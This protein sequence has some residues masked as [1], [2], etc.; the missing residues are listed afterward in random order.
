MTL[1]IGKEVSGLGKMTV[2]ELRARFAEVTGEATTS[3]HKE[4]LIRR[5][6]R[7]MQA[8]CRTLASIEA[9]AARRAERPAGQVRPHGCCGTESHPGLRG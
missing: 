4:N 6:I 2:P 9:T 8:I 3:R 5:I 1:N 7:R